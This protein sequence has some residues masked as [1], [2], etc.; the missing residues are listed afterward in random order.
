M[1]YTMRVLGVG[2]ASIFF[3]ISA[4][5]TYWSLK[6]IAD[7]SDKEGVY[8]YES[9]VA[10]Y[11]GKTMIGLTIIMSIINSLGAII[12]WNIFITD[13]LSNL[14][15]YFSISYIIYT[16]DCT[17]YLIGLLVVILVQVPFC[18]F[19]NLANV[20]VLSI[21][22]CVLI[23]YVFIVSICEFPYFLNKNFYWDRI[24]YFNFNVNIPEY[25]CFFFFAFGNHSTITNA[26]SEL[27]PKTTKRIHMLIDYTNYSEIIIYFITMLVGYFST[28]ETTNAIYINREY[29]SIFMIIGKFLYIGVMI[30]NIGLC[31]YMNLPYLDYAFNDFLEGR[32][33][34]EKYIFIN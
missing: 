17:K 32:I 20:H 29:Q 5:L 34:Q 15:D 1:P 31:Y 28:F 8:D 21:I 9:L 26:I 24:S 10:K 7:V 27:N 18:T 3:F 16:A 11:Y 30:S 4:G 2:T 19:N 22:G 13:I 33:S 25:L 12:A 6:L 23:F 14:F